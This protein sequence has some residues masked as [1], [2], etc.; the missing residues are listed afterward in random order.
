MQAIMMIAVMSTATIMGL[1][2]EPKK[3]GRP[4]T[5]DRHK[6]RYMAPILPEMYVRLR[7]LAAKHK[8]PVIWQIRIML[9]EALDA[10]GIPN[11]P[12]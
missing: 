2:S 5:A 6:K 10:E 8:R 1:M 9:E 7:A 11:G 4:R 12:E 3:P